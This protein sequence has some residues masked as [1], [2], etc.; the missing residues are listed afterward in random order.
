[1]PPVYKSPRIYAR[2]ICNPINILNITRPPPRI[3]S[4]PNI[5]PSNL[6]SLRNIKFTKKCHSSSSVFMHFASAIDLPSFYIS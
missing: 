1:M 4:T 2:Q 3:F 6:L 5:G